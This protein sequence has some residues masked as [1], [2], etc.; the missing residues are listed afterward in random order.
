MSLQVHQFPCLADNYGFLLHD[1][2]SG[3]TT[4]ID[5]PDANAY[6]QQAKARGWTITQIWN[7]H[8]H[9]DHAGGNA[10]IKA[11]TQCTIYGPA[12]V[13]EHF[14]LDRVLGHGDTVALGE[15]R[16]QVIDVGGHTRG[17]IAYHLP[18][19]RIAFVG[20]S[21]F[22]LGCGRMFEGTPSQFWASLARLKALPADTMVYCAH[23]YTEANA[24]FA[25]HADPEN[26]AL[27]AYTD[28]VFA[29]RAR[30]EWTVPFPLARE[31]ETNPFLRADNP[32]IQARWGGRNP[33]ETFAA[34]RAAKDRF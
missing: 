24:R 1:T 7:T 12:E 32:A 29:A 21:L 19:S 31:L 34:L 23:E 28:E 26:A 22:A 11:A 6:L 27:R 3:E 15:H 14:P 17:H 13:G 5:T 16:A 20:D 25:L 9:P 33:A 4:C 8:W 18:G 2:E 10:A 30:G